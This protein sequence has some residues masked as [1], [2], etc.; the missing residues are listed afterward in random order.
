MPFAR[1]LVPACAA[2]LARYADR[3]LDCLDSNELKQGF[4]VLNKLAQQDYR[5]NL[6]ELLSG[7]TIG[8]DPSMQIGRLVGVVL[9]EPFSTP[10]DLDRPSQFS[11]AYRAWELLGE[12]A[13]HDYAAMQSWQYHVLQLLA[14]ETGHPD[15][16]RLAL[17]A[18]HERGFFGYLAR[19]A[20]KYI[21]GDARIRKEIKKAVD[22]VKKS[23]L[24]LS[25]TSPEVLVGSAG[26]S[27][28]MLLIQYAP[29]LG[30]VGAPAIAGFVLVIYRIGVDAFCEWTSSYDIDRP[31]EKI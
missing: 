2:H 23:G 12:S 9:K 30:V 19:S 27:L 26:L 29:I 7:S 22:E 28:A 4:A 31:L 25:V 1:S 21:C 6:D 18:H 20:A 3:G 17:D 11:G 10:I 8:I 5:Q 16:Y 15:A 14:H 24:N 13:F